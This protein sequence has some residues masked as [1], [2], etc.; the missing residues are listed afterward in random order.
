MDPAPR[1]LFHRVTKDALS[2][3]AGQQAKEV[4]I[5]GKYVK[6]PPR[7]VQNYGYTTGGVLSGQVISLAAKVPRSSPPWSTLPILHSPRMPAL[8]NFQIRQ[9]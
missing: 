4:K 5:N 9:I 2:G 6:Y 8:I 1:A 3:N 7:K